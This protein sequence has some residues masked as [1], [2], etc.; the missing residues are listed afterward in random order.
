MKS[1]APL[2]ATAAGIVAVIVGVF[3]FGDRLGLG[4]KPAEPKAPSSNV[5]S[6]EKSQ[7]APASS[8]SEDASN[9]A[10]PV[11]SA[12]PTEAASEE[13]TGPGDDAANQTGAQTAQENG[14]T[15]TSKAATEPVV[16]AG[17]T[18]E[19][20]SAEPV[21]GE[22]GTDAAKE[23]DIAVSS[24]AP[25][26][27]AGSDDAVSSETVAS[28]ASISPEQDAT[29]GLAE[30]VAPSFDIVR[31]EPDGNT[32]VAG[33]SSPDWMIELHNGAEVIART[34]ADANGEWVIILEKALEPG[35][36][37][38]SLAAM[39]AE[40][41][42]ALT[43]ASSVTVARPEDGK[44]E[45]L[46][47]ENIP[48]QPS[49]ILTK[50]VDQAKVDQA[51]KEAMLA[52]AGVTDAELAD[53]G[54]AAEEIATKPQPDPATEAPK[55]Q[56]MAKVEDKASAAA[57]KPESDDQAISAE[58]SVTTGTT[59]DREA[60]E[61]KKPVLAGRV[62]IEA[63]ELEGNTVFVAGAA[64]PAGSLLRMYVNNKA[65]SDTRSGETGRFLFDGELELEPGRH[66]LRVDL[67]NADN[68]TVIN[69]AEVAFVKKVDI[70]E[71][72]TAKTQIDQS[73]DGE[74]SG[75]A[76]AENA[77]MTKP[78]NEEGD[79]VKKSGA[80]GQGRMVKQDETSSAT[81]GET[82]KLLGGESNR[83]I[84]RRGDNLWEIARRVYGAGI[85]YST[86][87][88][89]NS[90]QIRDPHWIYP[91]QVFQ[92][93]KGEEGWETNFDA[94]EHPAADDMPVEEAQN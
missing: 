63:V 58:A 89:S 29:A 34:R 69:R 14:E 79:W 64:E 94:V 4:E 78:E 53:A 68:G 35:V 2:I 33:R 55:K 16:A 57:A 19:A 7:E 24:E 51:K 70:S 56:E 9:E 85:R 17:E 77:Q 8:R 88:D 18:K 22:Q 52:D 15:E 36:S 82:V 40:G 25:D 71:T 20:D 38:L 84:I 75:I 39:A 47:V 3:L 61:E 73:A 67:I 27:S 21:S 65:I 46:V 11:A 59:A 49:K 41:G 6:A 32:L 66:A 60:A 31:V 72:Q 10:T 91:G 90:G 23:A 80:E 54:K 92:L 83:V 43:S 37:D 28:D 81:G 48:G 93:P 74:A 62:S 30:G 76:S 1:T 86:I 26:I 45:L 42:E 50:I 12:A 13:N 5:T 87:Y 44:G